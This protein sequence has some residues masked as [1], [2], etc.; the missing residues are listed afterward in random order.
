MRSLIERAARSCGVDRIAL[1]RTSSRLRILCYHGIWAAPTAH[2][3][4]KLFMSPEKFESRLRLIKA[5]RLE[6]LPMMDALEGLYSGRLPARAAV[7][8]IDDGWAST[9]SHMLPMLEQYGYPATVYI[10]TERLESGVPVADVALRYAMERASVPA[11]ALPDCHVGAEEQPLGKLPLGNSLQRADAFE[12][13]ERQC[14]EKPLAEQRDFLRD[15]FTAA[16]LDLAELER[17]KAF[18]LATESELA[19]AHR[20]G[21]EMALHTHTHS[22]GDFSRDRIFEEITRNRTGLASMLGVAPESFRHFCWPSGDYTESAVASMQELDIKVATSCDFGLADIDSHRLAMPRIL[23]GQSM[24]D[25]AFVLA[26][27]GAQSWMQALLRRD[28]RRTISSAKS[29]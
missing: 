17:A 19:D 16:E 9:F 6:V 15:V 26:V 29:S 3:G 22:L 14:T 21:F 27:S 18:D 2:F 20:K 11:L 10:Q 25:D 28:S 24:S 4:D 1:A 23:D 5:Q 13:L 12:K 7:I 8:T